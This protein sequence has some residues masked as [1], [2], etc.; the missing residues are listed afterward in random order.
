MFHLVLCESPSNRLCLECQIL[1]VPFFEAERPS[2]QFILGRGTGGPPLAIKFICGNSLGHEAPRFLVTA[3]RTKASRSE[4]RRR[5]FKKD[6]PSLPRRV[7]LATAL[8]ASP[9]LS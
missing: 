4:C 1:E 9:H 6:T 5:P 8:D 7:V 3:G 2:L